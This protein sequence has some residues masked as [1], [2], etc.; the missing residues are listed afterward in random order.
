MK[1]S[2]CD[3]SGSINRFDPRGRIIG[4]IKCDTCKGSGQITDPEPKKK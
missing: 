4:K 3:G 2:D 1:C